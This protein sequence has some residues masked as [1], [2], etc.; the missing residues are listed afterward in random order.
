[1]SVAISSKPNL[2]KLLFWLD[3]RYN[4]LFSGKH[5][6]GKT[7]MILEAFK[8]AGLRYAYFSGST[9]DPFVDFVGVP[10]KVDGPGGPRIELIRPGHIIEADLQAIFFDEFN[11]T[12]RKIRNAVMELIQFKTINSKPIA[13]DLRV[14]WAA[15]NPDSDEDGGIYDTDRLDPAQRDR[16]HI[17]V[18]LPYKCSPE[19]FGKTFGEPTAKAAIQFWDELPDAE[20]D[21]ISPRRLDY[22]LKVFN[23]SGDVR[24]VLPASSNPSR[25]SAI[26]G[27]GPADEKLRAMVGD[28]AEAKRFLSNE[29][30]YSY[31]LKTIM[32]SSEYISEFVPSMPA[33]KMAGLYESNG[34]VRKAAHLDIRA[35]GRESAFFGV[36][37][38]IVVANQNV[39]LA[40]TARDRLA[41]LGVALGME[42][43][44]MYWSC[45]K[46]PAKTDLDALLARANKAS[47]CSDRKRVYEKLRSMIPQEMVEETALAIIGVC[48]ILC[49]GSYASV[50]RDMPDFVGIIDNCIANLLL[51]KG[52]SPNKVEEQIRKIGERLL[53]YRRRAFSPSAE[54]IMASLPGTK[55]ADPSRV[56]DR[57]SSE[58]TDKAEMK[59]IYEAYKGNGGPHS[60][61]KIE[62]DPQFGLKYAKGNNAYRVAKRYKEAIK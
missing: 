34:S 20:R 44:P 50:Q 12:H 14:I 27:T 17:H 7:A 39:K 42:S 32:A 8:S 38:E 51:S 59:V 3:K 21:K 26:L 60:Y 31:A 10:I 49:Y 2:K 16:F 28:P 46:Q 35:K 45:T 54:V 30:N 47:S 1:M 15:V 52:A 62:M 36:L 25:L 40:S 56:A 9:M 5:G 55:P 58:V 23:D 53:G 33:E 29:N 18:E 6:I 43:I 19:Y 4:V 57:T 48:E 22:A 13:S 24:D 41:K 37:R 61:E 11:R